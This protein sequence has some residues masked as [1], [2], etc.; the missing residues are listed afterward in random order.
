M[1]AGLLSLSLLLAACTDPPTPAPA[2]PAP[3]A[4]EDMTR[5][6]PVTDADRTWAKVYR[7]LD[8]RWRGTFKIYVD[9]RGQR[10]GPRPTAP[11]DLDPTPWAKPP[12]KLELEIAVEQE[13]VS[14]SDLF[15]RVTIKDTYADKTVVSRGVNKVQGGKLWCVVEKPDD[16]VVHAGTREGAHTL[17]WQRDR[18]AP[19]AVEYFR[20][21]V[22]AD[23]YSIVG[24]GYYGDDDPSLAPRRF[25]H[26]TYRRAR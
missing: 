19:L 1:R 25:F 4:I 10:P 21:T 22:R 11:D 24:W 5:A 20:E 13:Y 9:T 14:E 12:F 3:V 6:P 17:I 7:G 26:A 2:P 8:G 18:A 23:T 16:R 15:Q